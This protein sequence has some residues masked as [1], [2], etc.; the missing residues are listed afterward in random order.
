MFPLETIIERAASPQVWVRA[1]VTFDHKD[2]AREKRFQWNPTK[3]IWVKQF[4]QCD[5]EKETFDF[6]TIILHD[7]QP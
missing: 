5:L 2:K 4:K 7:Y 3:K 6:K 1:D